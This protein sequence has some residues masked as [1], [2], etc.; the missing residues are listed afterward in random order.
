MSRRQSSRSIVANPVLVGA[1]TTLVVVIAVF[2][3]Y[4]ANNGLPF[5]PTRQLKVEL[6]NG[7]ALL[8]GNDVRAGGFRIGIVE[9]MKPVRL[10]SGVVGAE[11][12]LK[13][14]KKVGEIPRDSIVTIRPRSVLGLKYVE[15][16]RGRSEETFKEGD[17]LPVS[18]SKL[19]VELDQLYNIFDKPTRDASQ[20]NLRGFGNTLTG[21]GVSLNRTIEEFPRFLT[22]LEPVMSTLGNPST[23]LG[24]FFKELGDAARVVAPVAQR[25]SHSFT[26]GADT[27]EAWS[28]SPESLKETISRS[29]PSLDAGIRSFPVQRPFLRDFARFSRALSRA[30]AELP[31]TLPRIT[32]TLRIGIPVLRRTPPVN[33][34]LAKTFTSMEELFESPGTGQALRGLVATANTLN[35][36]LRFVGPYIT[37]CN[38]FNYAWTNTADHLTEPDPTGTSQRT[39]LNQAPRQDNSPGSLGA[40]RPANGENVISGTPAHLHVN[41]YTAAVDRQ[42]NADCESG[43]RGYVRRLNTFGDPRNNIVTDPHIPGNQGPTFTGRARVLPGQTFSRAPTQ[44]PPMLPEFDP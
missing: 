29:V 3:A 21:R 33:L 4:N 10:D 30:A 5:V 11:A 15:I 16:A 6:P 19:P 43:Q 7:A 8:P 38:Y 31:R 24:T 25:Y 2:L 18:Q 34:E 9:D 23:G 36:T 17:T 14:D 41:L 42:G 35:P 27:F 40:A 20:E 37:V 28:R 26:A 32:P 44:G 22:H 1:V 13:I 39:L 12:V